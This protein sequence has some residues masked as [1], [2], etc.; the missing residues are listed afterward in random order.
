MARV[1]SG[2]L[3]RY[4]DLVR[5][6]TAA[7]Y[8][9]AVLFGAGADAEDV[10]QNAFVKA[11]QALPGF[12]DGAAFRPWLLR[13]VANEAK[14]GARANG[15][16]RRATIRYAELGMQDFLAPERQE[17]EASALGA[18]RRRD[19][20]AAVRRLPAAQQLVIACRYFLDLDEKETARVLRWPRGTVKSRSSRALQRLRDDLDGEVDDVG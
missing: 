5:T 10:V 18:E 11:Y 16:G 1:L 20:V 8:R 17:P 2:D 7:A 19:L 6:H 4:A 9:T 12:R 13:I 3:D 14:N 15:R